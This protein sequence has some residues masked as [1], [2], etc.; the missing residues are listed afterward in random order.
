MNQIKVVARVIIFGVGVINSYVHVLSHK[1]LLK[2]IVKTINFNRNYS[3]KARIYKY[4][5]PQI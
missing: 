5:L 1:F 2:L 3:R 4:S